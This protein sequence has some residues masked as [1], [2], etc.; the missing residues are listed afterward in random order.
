VHYLG[1]EVGDIVAIAET[2]RRLKYGEEQPALPSATRQRVP[3]AVLTTS[4][5][6]VTR[7]YVGISSWQ[8]ASGRRRACPEHV[9][10]RRKAKA[11]WH[12]L[13]DRDQVHKSGDSQDVRDAANKEKLSQYR[14]APGAIPGLD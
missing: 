13:I 6:M 14:A 9:G 4:A 3:E 12:C 1:I 5:A 8:S 7:L 10:F 2:G 11:R